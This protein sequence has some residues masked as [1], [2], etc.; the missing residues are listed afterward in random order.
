MRRVRIM[1]GFAAVVCAFSAFTASAFAKPPKEKIFYGEF[2]A[3]KFGQTFTE[4]SPA[5]VKGTGE[6]ESP[7][8]SGKETFRL[9]PYGIRC[10]APF[11]VEG[12]L[13]GP[14]SPEFY[15]TLKFRHCE[16]EKKLEG[17]VISLSPIRFS[18]PLHLTYHANGSVV[19]DTEAGVKISKAVEK[20]DVKGEDC[21]VEI[22]EQTLP[23]RAEKKPEPEEPYS[24]AL[25][26]RES[27]EVLGGKKTKEMFPG[28]P[29]TGLEEGEQETLIIES[30]FTAIKAD[31][32]ANRRCSKPGLPKEEAEKLEKE[33][34]PDRIE[35]TKGLFESLLTV[36]LKKGDIG[37]EEA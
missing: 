29:L 21:V 32:N 5:V 14:R 27:E 20:F 23:L 17:G 11:K 18:E 2:I 19:T 30:D 7:E 25:Y 4:E 34:K 12:E 16:A 13:L 10:L 3:S 9:G 33:G 28:N 24:D 22:P 35:T 8:K 36:K 6:V 31:Y 37:F 1:L 26:E 15:V